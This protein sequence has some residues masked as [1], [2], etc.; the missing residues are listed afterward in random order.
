MEFTDRNNKFD[1][2]KFIYKFTNRENTHNSNIPL[3]FSDGKKTHDFNIDSFNLS[4]MKVNVKKPNIHTIV[5]INDIE[6]FKFDFD[7]QGRI[8]QPLPTQKDYKLEQKI[9]YNNVV[10]KYCDMV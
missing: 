10:D 1:I 8:H 3:Y 2:Q 5:P 4:T 7:F 9:T 6:N